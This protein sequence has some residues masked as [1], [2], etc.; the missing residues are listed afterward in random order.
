MS[1]SGVCMER[2]H[3]LEPSSAI[4]H[5]ALLIQVPGAA[6]GT[7]DMKM[8]KGQILTQGRAQL[9]WGNKYTNKSLQPHGACA[10]GMQPRAICSI[11]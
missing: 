4:G 10:L 9:S 7:E 8:S 2:G 6:S 11:K 3:L 1:C 5:S